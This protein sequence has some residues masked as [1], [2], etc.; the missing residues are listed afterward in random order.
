[1]KISNLIFIALLLITT[2]CD[3]EDTVQS[4]EV[5]Y[6]STEMHGYTIT[7]RK[8]EQEHPDIKVALDLLDN[9]LAEINTL[10]REEKLELI[11]NNP[12]WL[13]LDLEEEGACLYHPS[14]QWL[15]ANDQ[16]PD[17]ELCIEIVN[18]GNFVNWTNLNQPY[19]ILHEMAHLI[20]HQFF[21]NDYHAIEAAFNKTK[22]SGIYES[23][24]YYDGNDTIQK[25]AY[26]LRNNKEYFAELTEAFLGNNDFYPF[27]YN[28]LKEFDTTGF[29]LMQ[30][31][32]GT[33]PDK[34]HTLGIKPPPEELELD[35]FYKK[36]LDA[37]GLP[38]ISSWIVHDE[39][40]ILAR[41]IVQHMT[42]KIPEKALNQMIEYDIRVG[43]IGANQNTTD[44]PEY[45]D[46]YDVFPGTDWDAR[47]RGLGPTIERPLA[48]CGEEN[49]LQ[50]E[51]DRYEGEIILIHE[52]AHAI[53]LM[54]LKPAVP[55]FD[56]D[57]KDAYN[58]A[59]DKGLWENTYAAVN[60]EEYFAEGVQ[61]WYNANQYSSPPDGV[62]NHVD[63]R[64]KLKE[65][66]RRLYDIIATYFPDNDVEFLK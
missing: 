4:S 42:S 3:K 5:E 9:K 24:P 41:D 31:T 30:S 59:M 27:N 57:L 60:Y 21:G 15:L 10:L 39:A 34:E 32:W 26:A 18:A 61:S 28:D 8:S 65:Y 29:H 63:T 19:M 58:E 45:N 62:H 44:M 7:M 6:V 22:N 1:M 55:G 46:L 53:H 50:L 54:G 40:L 33:P 64:E 37:K 13:K 25:E 2:N 20:H 36:Y 56:D 38:V 12:V 11:K 17:K 52:F 47:T 51:G 16:N 23:V 66:D 14:R 48:S 49:L 35:S 43:I